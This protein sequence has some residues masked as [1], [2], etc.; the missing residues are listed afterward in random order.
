MYPAPGLMSHRQNA[1]AAAGA[2]TGAAAS[3]RT[4]NV[5]AAVQAAPTART[6]HPAHPAPP[7]ARA[8][9]QPAAHANVGTPAARG[10]IIS[11]LMRKK[12][13]AANRAAGSTAAGEV[14]AP[15]PPSHG[16]STA[17]AAVAAAVP[18]SL[19]SAA[20][21][22]AHGVTPA[23][24]AGASVG[25]GSASTSPGV[26]AV[27]AA[28]TTNGDSL[29]LGIVPR[30]ASGAAAAVASRGTA[31]AGG[32]REGQPFPVTQNSRE[33][34]VRSTRGPIARAVSAGAISTERETAAAAAR[35]GGEA[36]AATIR[37]S[38]SQPGSQFARGVS[39]AVPGSGGRTNLDLAVVRQH[40]VSGQRVVPA[41][42]SSAP[43]VSVASAAA[44]ATAAAAAAA[45]YS[46]LPFRAG[47]APTTASAARR[48]KPISPHPAAA[49]VATPI[50]GNSLQTMSAR[51]NN[52]GNPGARSWNGRSASSSTP[53][54]NG[55]GNGRAAGNGVEPWDEEDGNGGAAQAGGGGGQGRAASGGGGG[56]EVDAWAVSPSRVLGV[57][58]GEVVGYEVMEKAAPSGDTVVLLLEQTEVSGGTHSNW[59][60]LPTS[61]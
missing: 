57:G 50:G 39:P 6:A 11:K 23:A 25:W 56:G 54:S 3:R 44:T 59:R 10:F 60:E 48:L 27:T 1:P 32:G 12:K 61:R 26:A 46:T 13:T 30:A 18:G 16:A 53:A 17:P 22:G 7:H 21:I 43:S 15:T 4:P 49:V 8:P 35:A 5:A 40:Q 28:V 24:A 58:G 9:A 36:W 37:R 29:G 33:A 52:G 47:V 51:N 55:G 2:A 19:N 20:N 31:Q 34:L 45:R 14:G 41:S 42:S 38:A